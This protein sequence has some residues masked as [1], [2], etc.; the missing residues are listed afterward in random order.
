MQPFDRCEAHSWHSFG[1]P[2]RITRM[3]CPISQIAP[4]EHALNIPR[5]HVFTAIGGY[6]G[7]AVVDL[8]IT[9]DVHKDPTDQFAWPVPFA[10]R[11][12]SSSQKSAKQS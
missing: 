11:F 10:A 5:W 9:G 6:I 12:M 1:I 4:E 3:V 8:V 7:V 2:L